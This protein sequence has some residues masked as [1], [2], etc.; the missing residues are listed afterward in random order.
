M[1]AI[2]RQHYGLTID[3]GPFG[4]SSRPA[5]IGSKFAESQGLGDAYHTAVFR[6]YWQQ[7]MSIEEVTLLGIAESVGLDRGRF[8]AALTDPAYEN[9]LLADV[10]EATEIGLQGVPALIFAGRFLVSGAQSYDKLAS[11]ANQIGARLGI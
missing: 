6:A 7:A 3:S 1:E 9:A 5:L 11:I 8:A 4:V 2:A 10:S